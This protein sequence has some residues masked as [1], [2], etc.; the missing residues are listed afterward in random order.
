MAALISNLKDI[1]DKVFLRPKGGGDSRELVM[2]VSRWDGGGD[3]SAGRYCA[4]R[5]FGGDFPL[6]YLIRWYRHY[7]F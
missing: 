2:Q 5:A 6:H 3:G 4:G 1:K 7:L